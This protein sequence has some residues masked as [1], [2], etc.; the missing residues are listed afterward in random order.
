MTWERANKIFTLLFFVI[1]FAITIV[2]L[3]EG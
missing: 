1:A 2:L 3:I